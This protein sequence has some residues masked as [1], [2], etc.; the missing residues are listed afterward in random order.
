[1]SLKDLLKDL[2]QVATVLSDQKDQDPEIETSI[3]AAQ[4]SLPATTLDRLT[5]SSPSKLLLDK[6]PPLPLFVKP[7]L[8]QDLL[9]ECPTKTKPNTKKTSTQ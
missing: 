9:H 4:I 6:S 8:A 7:T 3:K 1:M 2:D 5:T